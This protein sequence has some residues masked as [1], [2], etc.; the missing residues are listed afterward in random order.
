MSG[1]LAYSKHLFIQKKTAWIAKQKT[2]QTTLL[3]K[4]NMQKKHILIM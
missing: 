3:Q 2:C 1:R 4:K